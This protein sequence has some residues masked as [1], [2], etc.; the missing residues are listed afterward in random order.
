VRDL[1]G[2]LL[3]RTARREDANELAEF[4]GA[5]H[6][7]EDISADE[8]AT[9]TLDLFETPHSTFRPERDVVVVEDTAT[10]RIVSSV[11]LIP[12]VWSYAGVPLPVGQPELVATHPDYRRRGLIRAQFDVIH[13]RS[14]AAGHLWQFITGIPWYY[15]QFGYSYALDIAPF[16]VWWTGAGTSPP[17]APQ[18]ITLRPATRDDIAFLAESEAVA[19][20][21]REPVLA[22]LRGAGGWELEL[23]RRP[24]GLVTSRVLIIEEAG[25]IG[26]VVLGEGLRHGLARVWS[27]VLHPGRSWLGPTATVFAHVHGWLQRQPSGPGRG[28]RLILPPEHPAVRCA[29]TRLSRPLLGHDGLYVRVPDLLSLLRAIVPALEAR[30]AASFAAGH[31]GAVTVD[32]YRD[33]LRFT[34]AEGRISTID[35]VT[36][37]GEG[38]ASMRRDD[39]VHLVFGNRSLTELER[40]AADCLINSDAGAALLDVLFPSLSLWLFEMG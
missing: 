20:N 11:L 17:P 6:A 27:F 30:L 33:A 14:A 25:P 37:H 9:W 7:D 23:N 31:S 18:G 28:L 15:R 1:G 21:G 22:C 4:N 26:Y 40:A 34:F 16:P 13:E 8:V 32:L 24:R 2:G 29:A 19:L 36:S 3:L 12:Q 10:G 5:M 35:S 39:F 38:D